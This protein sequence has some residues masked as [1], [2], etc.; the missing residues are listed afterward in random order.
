MA[1]A[2]LKLRFPLRAELATDSRPHLEIILVTRA[3]RLKTL[4]LVTLAAGA[5]LGCGSSISQ[6][7]PS[8]NPSIDQTSMRPPIDQNANAPVHDSDLELDALWKQRTEDGA[9]GDAR[10]Q[11]TLG[12]GDLLRISVPQIDQLR[13]RTVRVSEDDTIALPLLG[14][15]S[16]AGMT[17]DDLREQLTHR[18]AKYMYHPQVEVFLEHTEHRQAA[19]IG[20]VKRPGRYMLAS[21][22]DT[23]MSLISR[24][25]G[26]SEDA[27]SRVILVPAPVP[28]EHDKLSQPTD[29]SSSA[30]APLP[31][32][33][34]LDP[35]KGAASD[36]SSALTGEQLN[37]P[38]ASQTSHDDQYLIDLSHPANQRYLEMTAEQGDVIIVP[39]AGEVTV[40]G[41]VDKPGA[42]K[43]TPQM[44]VLGSIAA[45]G[46]PN[47]TR[48]ATLL[49]T[50][51]SGR[52]LSIPFD[53]SKLKTGEQTDLAVQSGDVIIVNK[54][55]IGAVPY[56][57]Y[58]LINKVGLG[59]PI[60]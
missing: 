30:G 14:S 22:E 8:P 50:D 40:Q 19:V 54:S 2:W 16:V 41:W 28:D 57:F 5:L 12:A 15:F 23:L 39:A 42:F 37:S 53:I 13:D 43:I 4:S 26:F 1:D 11:F 36:S 24:A 20:S 44:T 55:V 27:A 10:Q 21:R 47:F 34:K 48:S 60:F 9:R 45:A 29:R 18:V 49:R 6:A 56:S 52:K 17:E 32:V 58:F 33:A 31:V 46:G 7:Q 38:S 35:P 51:D 59:L 3:N 25:G